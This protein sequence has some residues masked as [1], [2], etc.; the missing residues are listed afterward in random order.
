MMPNERDERLVALNIDRITYWL[1]EGAICTKP[2]TTLLGRCIHRHNY[3]LQF[4]HG[5][6]FSISAII[7]QAGFLPITPETYMRAWRRRK[8][9]AEQMNNAEKP[10]E[11]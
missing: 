5:M 9:L 3:L 8:Q 6:N 11:S 7:G 10:N 1:S 2:V 4:A